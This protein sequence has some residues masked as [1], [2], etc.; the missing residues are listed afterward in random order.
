MKTLIDLHR[1]GGFVVAMDLLSGISDQ[2]KSEKEALENLKQGLEDHFR[3]LIDM[4]PPEHTLSC[5]EIAVDRHVRNSP[6]FVP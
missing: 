5:M 2:G 1:E 4:T 6:A 3:L